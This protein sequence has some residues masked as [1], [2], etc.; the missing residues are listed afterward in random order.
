MIKEKII[1]I[2]INSRTLKHYLEKGYNGKINDNIFVDVLDLPNGS[3][4]I[5]TGI[6]D[7][8]G[9]EKEIQYKTYL[10]NYN[11]YNIYTC[12][13]CCI[14]KKEKTS[15]ENYGVTHASK[16]KNFQKKMQ[17]Y[18][19][20]KYGKK[21]FFQTDIFLN[22][23]GITLKR[24]ETRIK[25]GFSIDDK[26]KTEWEL[27]KN[28]IRNK[29][30]KNKKILIEKWDGYDYYDGEY[31]K[32]NFKKYKPRSSKYPSFD[33][34]ISLYYGFINN[35]DADIISDISNLCITKTIINN[36]KKTRTEDEYYKK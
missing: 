16:N 20:E 7:I 19:L 13:K 30:N 32:D 23:S 21:S 14:I 35:I 15:L 3:H 8:C 9:M 5:I 26:Y 28:K 17:D 12:H 18:N 24:K 2:K 27:Y 25:N 1:K 10:R 4:T 29:T 22:N 6:C 33:H 31:I 34:K 11:K 36:I